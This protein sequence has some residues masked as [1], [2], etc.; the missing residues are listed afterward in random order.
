SRYTSR[1]TKVCLSLP[2][3]ATGKPTGPLLGGLGS[4]LGGCLGVG[5][6]V[7]CRGSCGGPGTG[8]SPPP[9]PDPPSGGTSA[10]G[11]RPDRTLTTSPTCSSS[12]SSTTSYSSVIANR[13]SF[14]L[15]LPSPCL[16]A[17]RA[18]SGLP[19]WSS[20]TANVEPTKTPRTCPPQPSA[21][22]KHASVEQRRN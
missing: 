10:R 16:S 20:A 13:A 5:A 12:R 4:Y 7:G 18:S 9:Y 17:S 1:L 2:G 15:S 3:G 11:S 8:P 14:F 22:A 6:P 19:A 21:R